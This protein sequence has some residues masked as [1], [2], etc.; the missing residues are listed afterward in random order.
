MTVCEADST[1][2]TYTQKSTSDCT[3]IYDSESSETSICSG[4][5]FMEDDSETDDNLPEI[6]PC[7]VDAPCAG[8]PQCSAAPS[9][10]A[11]QAII[12]FTPENCQCCKSGKEKVIFFLFSFVFFVYRFFIFYPKA[13]SLNTSFIHCRLLLYYLLTVY[14]V[15]GNGNK[16]IIHRLNNIIL[17][18]ILWNF[19]YRN[20]CI[21]VK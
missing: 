18:E 6:K 7:S 10:P 15:Q 5:M 9:S 3:V 21:K 4:P 13:L 14:E 16:Q 12:T 2:H 20:P 11:S 17:S 19:K 8:P 1:T